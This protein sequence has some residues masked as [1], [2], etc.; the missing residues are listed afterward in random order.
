MIIST[1]NPLDDIQLRDK[2][3]NSNL[4]TRHHLFKDSCKKTTQKRSVTNLHS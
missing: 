3:G 2:D 4:I 1:S